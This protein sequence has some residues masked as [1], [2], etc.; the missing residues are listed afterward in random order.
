VAYIVTIDS[1][2]HPVEAS[3]CGGISPARFRKAGGL[4]QNANQPA[5]KREA[6]YATIA[7]IGAIMCVTFVVATASFHHPAV[8]DTMILDT[9]AITATAPT[10]PV[11]ASVKPVESNAYYMPAQFDEGHLPSNSSD[12]PTF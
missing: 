10:P 12:A 7:R 1:T 11:Q 6:R 8:D 5:D 2:Q 9:S 3:M 4:M